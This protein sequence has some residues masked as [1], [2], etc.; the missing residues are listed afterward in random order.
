MDRRERWHKIYIFCYPDVNGFAA[1]Q[2]P[3]IA[4]NW[5]AKSK[6]ELECCH[7]PESWKGRFNT[8]SPS[9][10]TTPS[11]YWPQC[12]L[13]TMTRQTGEVCSTDHLPPPSCLSHVHDKLIIQSCIFTT[14]SLQPTNSPTCCQNRHPPPLPESVRHVSLPLLQSHSATSTPQLCLPL[15]II[16]SSGKERHRFP[17]QPSL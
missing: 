1:L 14:L 9:R 11:K 10:F 17:F 4:E 16:S 12:F 8:G 2:Q 3:T 7:V 13:C 5:S 15:T 6:R